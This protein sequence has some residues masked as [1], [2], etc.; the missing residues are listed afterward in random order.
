VKG[1]RVRSILAP[2]VCW[3]VLASG[4]T[5]VY[6][7]WLA[8]SGA[9]YDSLRA[10]V[11]GLAAR[12]PSH[13]FM[14]HVTVVGDVHGT[15]DDIAHRA[16]QLARRTGVLEAR[17]TSI[18][19]KRGDY[20]RSFYVLIDETA[21]FSKLYEDTCAVI[22]KCQTR[23]YHMSVMYTDKLSDS[24]RAVIRDSLYARR[25]TRSF[26]RTVRLTRLLVCATSGLP[27][28]EWTCPRE[29]KLE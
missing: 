22:G 24:A 4:P 25:G 11:C 26:G 21:G 18:E 3:G 28:E 12:Y 20:F 16:E 5:N 15:L 23:P 1:N 2:M 10:L 8:P 14:P 17:F 9:Q 19:W 27:P 7:I 29:M 13:C 6:S